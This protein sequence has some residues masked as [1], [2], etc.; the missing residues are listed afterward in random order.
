MC[1]LSVSSPC[2]LGDLGWRYI[3]E[4]DLVIRLGEARVIE[5]DKERNKTECNYRGLDVLLHLLETYKTCD[6]VH[7]SWY[8]CF[9]VNI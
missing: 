1:L 7:D 9:F 2:C 8:Y 4:G 6:I 5:E 3:G